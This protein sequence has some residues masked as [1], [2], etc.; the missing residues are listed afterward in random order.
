[1]V[2]PAAAAAAGSRP[3]VFLDRDGV[4]VVPEFRCGRSYAPK[5]LHTFRLYNSAARE[6]DR[7]KQARYLL[8]VVTN[9]PDVGRGDIAPEVLDEMHRRLAAELPVDLVETCIHEGKDSC[10]CRKPKPGMLLAAAAKLNIDLTASF[11]VG[12]RTSDVEAGCAAGCRTVFIDRQYK[13][14]K[15]AHCTFKVRSL[16]EAVDAILTTADHGGCGG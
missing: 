9:Q 5:T 8:V 11:M 2:K 12:D 16:A 10:A 3:A 14:P 15:P 7:L 6:L 4:V 13:E 1:M